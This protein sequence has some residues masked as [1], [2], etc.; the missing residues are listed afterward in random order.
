MLRSSNPFTQPPLQQEL[1]IDHQPQQRHP[2]PQPF[3]RQR[4]TRPPPR[5]PPPRQTSLD[6]IQHHSQTSTPHT[7]PAASLPNLNFYNPP[8]QQQQNHNNSLTIPSYYH[9]QSAALNS[10][11]LYTDHSNFVNQEPIDD[12]SE[13]EYEEVIEQPWECSMCTFRNHPQ[14]N[15]CEACENVRIPGRLTNLSR[16]RSAT[17]C[18]NIAGAAARS[19]AGTALQ[20]SGSSPNLGLSRTPAGSSN[21]LNNSNSGSRNAL[22]TATVNLEHDT[23]L[24]QQQLQHYALHT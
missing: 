11:H 1:A 22:N 12:G 13:E 7:P 17:N 8:Q 9:Q 3:P 20:V 15:I 18:T 10:N 23:N 19:P 4:M 6:I 24:V 5:P 16:A 21:T 14:L 2:Q